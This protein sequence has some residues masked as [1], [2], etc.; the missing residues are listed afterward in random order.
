[1]DAEIWAGGEKVSDWPHSELPDVGDAIIVEIDG[2]DEE[3]EVT[4]KG[5]VW[6][7]YGAKKTRIE[8]KWTGPMPIVI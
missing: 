7:K 3:A 2:K 4:K 6:D 5:S 8:V 1:M